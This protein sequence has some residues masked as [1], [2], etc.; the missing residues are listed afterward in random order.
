MAVDDY[1]GAIEANL[2]RY[3]LSCAS[4]PAMSPMPQCSAILPSLKRKMPHE[5]KE[6]CFPVGVTPYSGPHCVPS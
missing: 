6:S 5:V 2:R 4:T 1:N 3:P